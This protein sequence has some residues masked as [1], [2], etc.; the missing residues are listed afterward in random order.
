MVEYVFCFTVNVFLIIADTEIAEF[1]R[2]AFMG[3]ERALWTCAYSAHVCIAQLH[4]PDCLPA[5]QETAQRAVQAG[6]AVQRLQ[7]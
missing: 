1:R 3:G 7:L 6:L 4:A 5:L 2:A